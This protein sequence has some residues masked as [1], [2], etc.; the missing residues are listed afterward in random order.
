[1]LTEVERAEKSL[2]EA[3]RQLIQAQAEHEVEAVKYAALRDAAAER[4]N[5]FEDDSPY[6]HREIWPHADAHWGEFRFIKM[7][8]GDA[9]VL[10]LMETDQRLNA[11]QIQRT[12]NSAGGAVD[13][14]ALNAALQ[15][16][17]GIQKAEGE[18][19][20]AATYWYA[21]D[22]KIDPDDLPF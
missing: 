13:M 7:N 3:R 9:A 10:A 19:E 5:P 4:F 1:M 20:S 6:L 14:R 17:G 16:R 15:Q 12:I 21:K 18:N 2:A 8:A 11:Y 22:E